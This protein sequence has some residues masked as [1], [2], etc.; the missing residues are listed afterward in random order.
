MVSQCGNSARGESSTTD[1]ADRL[2]WSTDGLEPRLRLDYW[3]GAV[4]EAFLKVECSSNEAQCFSGSIDS[5]PMPSLRLSHMR[6]S[7]Q[8]LVVREEREVFY[9]ATHLSNP[10]AVRQDGRFLQMRQGDV[11]LLDASR[12]YSADL[13]HG[14]DVVVIEVAPTWVGQ[15]LKQIESHGPR[16]ASRDQGWGRCLS[17]LCLQFGNDLN[18]ARALPLPVLSE[19][20]GAMLMAALEPASCEVAPAGNSELLRRARDFMM[21]RLDEPGLTASAI[22]ECLGVSIRTLHRVFAG[23]QITFASDLRRLRLERAAI[24]LVKPNLAAL[25]IAELGCRCGFSDSSHFVREFRR[26]WGVTP[27]R[28][29]IDRRSGAPSPPAMLAA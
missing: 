28:W 25:T 3:T 19:Q 24:L 1:R 27:G 29:R 12:K 9:L 22:A 21:Q 10:W 23:G 6:G 5:L 14:N 20:I 2:R 11:A 15:W 7:A 16:V 8:K 18:L 26:Q 4:C 17:T 13:A